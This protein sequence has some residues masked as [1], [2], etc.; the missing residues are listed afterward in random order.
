M[1]RITRSLSR[2]NA[3]QR[4]G[5]GIDNDSFPNPDGAMSRDSQSTSTKQEQPGEADAEEEAAAEVDKQISTYL[6]SWNN[7]LGTP[8][9]LE[10]SP[11]SQRISLFND[12][13]ME[14]ADAVR[15]R[16][17]L[18]FPDSTNRTEARNSRLEEARDVPYEHELSGDYFPPSESSSRQP[19]DGDARPDEP[20]APH[21]QSPHNDNL[22]SG[23]PYSDLSEQDRLII[24]ELHKTRRSE[25]IHAGAGGAQ[26]RERERERE[27]EQ[28]L[29]PT[30][31]LSVTS[32][33]TGRIRKSRPARR[34]VSGGTRRSAR[35]V[36]KPLAIFHKYVELP[37]ELQ[38]MVWEAAIQPRLT[39]I[40]NRWSTL[41]HAS[42]F[43]VQ[44]ALP[45]WFMTC[46]LSAYI[47][48]RN[49]VK[50]FDQPY[51]TTPRH[52]A[53][54]SLA[55]HISPAVDIVIYEPCH[56]GCRGHF[57]AQQYSAQDRALVRRLVVQLDSPNLIGRCEPGWATVSRSWPNIE[58]LFMM[59]NA[60]RGLNCEEKAMIR[61]KENDHMLFLRKEFDKWK[62]SGGKESTL[63]K[64]EFVQ[65]V[66]REEELGTVGGRYLSVMARKTG[67]PEDIIIG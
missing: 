40:C 36:V 45:S 14:Y 39:Y 48:K 64:L 44:N 15:S 25:R 52:S 5:K 67:L 33:K 57:C 11:A 50:S 24:E 62:L 66:K 4:K 56:G 29:P 28:E 13:S 10:S 19:Q 53:V 47:A 26:T 20:Q 9:D 55:Q 31:A 18:L 37:R 54:R 32:P 21:E 41:P 16:P 61:I 2:R 43:G 60:I 3:A 34:A 23:V 8:S 22:T 7:A 17:R 59:R 42:F 30:T 51:I 1:V 46:K 38:M 27:R 58:T 63:T 65:V 6:T 12:L 35:L 49:Y